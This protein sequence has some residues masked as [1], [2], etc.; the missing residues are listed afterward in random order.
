MQV[1]DEM[2]R[3]TK[4]RVE[5]LVAVTGQIRRQVDGFHGKE[6]PASQKL[7]EAEAVL[8]EAV[9]LLDAEQVQR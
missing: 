6:H 4:E 1:Q 3:W 7:M 9:R 5:R 8:R 2:Q